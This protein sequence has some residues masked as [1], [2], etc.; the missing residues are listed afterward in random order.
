MTGIAKGKVE[1][2]AYPDFFTFQLQQPVANYGMFDVWPHHK[3]V[4]IGGSQDERA[5]AIT[6]RAVNFLLVP[7]DRT[8]EVTI[9]TGWSRKRSAQYPPLLPLLDFP[10]WLSIR[11]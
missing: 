5:A 8:G 7:E 2:F 3:N 4:F 11:I 10:G 9:E 6:D 1:F